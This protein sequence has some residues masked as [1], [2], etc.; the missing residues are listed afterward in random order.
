MFL[1]A[2]KDYELE[3]KIFS[4]VVY[5]LVAALYCERQTHCELRIYILGILIKEHCA[6][7]ISS[8]PFVR[9]ILSL[10]GL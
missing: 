5:G 7:N 6:F 9:H 8:P 4:T 2:E 10:E 3:F 1:G